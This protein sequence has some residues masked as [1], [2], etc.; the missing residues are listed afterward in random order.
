MNTVK[1]SGVVTIS[2]LKNHV[3]GAQFHWELCHKILSGSV[4]ALRSIAAPSDI[5]KENL[6][7]IRNL[8]HAITKGYVVNYWHAT[9]VISVM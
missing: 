8:A 1:Q 4:L 5:N 7:R 2:V 3:I 9:P 6:A